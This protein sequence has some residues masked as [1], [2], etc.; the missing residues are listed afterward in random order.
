M[1]GLQ[2]RYTFKTTWIGLSAENGACLL[3]MGA[4]ILWISA[5]SWLDGSW[6]ADVMSGLQMAK[7]SWY[8]V[9]IFSMIPYFA[10]I[11]VG[12]P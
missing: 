10:D 2:L 1:R 12:H 6:W 8:M 5:I 7:Y 9:T 4:V 3:L 11:S